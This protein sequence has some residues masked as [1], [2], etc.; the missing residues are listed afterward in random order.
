MIDLIVHILKKYH[1][2]SSHLPDNLL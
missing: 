1:L 2:N